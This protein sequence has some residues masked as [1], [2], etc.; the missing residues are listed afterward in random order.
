MG[1]VSL[2]STRL[3]MGLQCSSGRALHPRAYGQHTS[4]LIYI[5]LKKAQ[6]WVDGGGFRVSDE[7]QRGMK[8]YIFKKS[9]EKL[10][11][12]KKTPHISHINIKY[13]LYRLF[14]SYLQLPVYFERL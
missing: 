4:D 13:L 9:S 6:N 12:N 3:L 10:I 1:G 11:Q 7:W 5:F 8:K 14:A 2:F